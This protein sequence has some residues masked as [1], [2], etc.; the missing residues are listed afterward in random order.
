[1]SIIDAVEC[2]AA[3]D[4]VT[5]ILDRR[6]FEQVARMKVLFPLAIVLVE[7]NLS[8]VPHSI[9]QEAVRGALT[10]RSST[11]PIWSKVSQALGRVAHSSCSLTSARRPQSCAPAPR[12]WRGPRASG[13]KVQ[14]AS[15]ARPHSRRCPAVS[16]RRRAQV[17]SA[18]GKSFPP[19]RANQRPQL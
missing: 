12:R 11:P 8:L 19:L 2:K 4:F 17:S 6:L 13:A 5:S 3:A 14:S 18:Q 15:G 16:E 10:L 7:G 9:D 1:M